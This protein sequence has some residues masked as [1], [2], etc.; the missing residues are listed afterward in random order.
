MAHLAHI[1]ENDSENNKLSVC[2]KREKPDTHLTHMAH[3]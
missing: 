1:S 3:T 2:Q